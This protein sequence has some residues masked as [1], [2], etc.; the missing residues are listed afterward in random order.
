MANV[1]LST[2]K[3]VLHDGELFNKSTRDFIDSIENKLGYKFKVSELDDYDCDLKLIFIESGGSE[4]LFLNDF[5]KF[6]EP[7]YFLTSGANN[8]L[9]ATLE[10]LTYLN[11][12][13]LKG[14]II[15]GDVDYIVN[16]IN[17]LTNK[18]KID[19]IKGQQFGVIGKPSDW[20]ISSIPNYKEI[21]DMFSIKLIDIPLN[22]LE[23]KYLSMNVDDNLDTL[24]FPKNEVLNATKVVNSLSNIVDKYNLSGLTIR[25]FDL[26]TSIKTT[27]CLGLAKLNKDGIIATCEG[28]IMAMISMA[29]LKGISNKSSFQAN[30]SRINVK[31]NTVVFAHCTL[32]L[33]MI[34]SYKYMTHFESGIGLAIKGELKEDEE[35]TVFRLSSD[36]KNYFVSSGKI[37]RNLNDP[38]L[39]RTQIEVKLDE[40]VNSLLTSPCGNHHII[41][42]G[43]YVKQIKEMF[44]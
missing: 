3:S 36:L 16:R 21:E 40:D 26:L 31:D 14:E 34:G 23:N 7:Y 41:V 25:C 20:L 18:N 29:I 13:G 44:K 24:G 19:V 5:D 15:H 30:P 22:E 32:S 43:N 9:A 17:Q 11:T 37:I 35:I 38:H 1:K 4:G 28:D 10:I 2:F 39:C 27:G 8:S 6:E 12:K 42:Y 33:D